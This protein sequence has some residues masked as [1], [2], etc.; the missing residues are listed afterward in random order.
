MT[1]EEFMEMV[2]S[3]HRKGDAGCE[4]CWWDWP[5]LCGRGGC[6]GLVHA[7]HEEEYEDGY[8]LKYKCDE[9]GRGERVTG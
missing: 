6:L 7:E 2:Y 1:A 5:E 8:T 3:S 9:C 4:Q